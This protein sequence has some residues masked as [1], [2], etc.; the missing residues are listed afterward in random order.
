MT[1]RP[2]PR[3]Y[4]RPGRRPHVPS[5][6][7]TMSKSRRASSPG[8]IGSGHRL[9]RLRRGAKRTPTSYEAALRCWRRHIWGGPSGVNRLFAILLQI[10]ARRARAPSSA[11]AQFL[12]RAS[13]LV[14]G[15]KRLRI[16]GR[17]R[18]SG[19]RSRIASA[20]ASIRSIRCFTRSPIETIPRSS[21]A[22]DDRQMANPPLGH[23]RQCRQHVACRAS[24]VIA[25][26]LITRA[27]R[28]VEHLGAMVA[29]AVDDVAL[30]D[31]AGDPPAVDHRQGADPLLAEPRDRVA[32]GARRRRSSR[33]RCPWSRSTAAMVMAVLP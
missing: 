6:K 1:D 12:D 17:V 15:R 25:G 16:C 23:Q 5:S 4:R 29:Q 28:P 20:S 26:E 18:R 3:G 13:P 8:S 9:Y 10:A 33:P 11:L 30:R 19:Y 7:P 14:Q 22:L 32:T 24:T 27:D 2:I 21:A 31:D